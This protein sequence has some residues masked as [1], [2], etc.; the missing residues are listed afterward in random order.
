MKTVM[1]ILLGLISNAALAQ[2]TVCPSV[3]KSGPREA[4]LCW[5]NA[6]KDVNGNKLPAS[7]PYALIETRIQRA[8][9]GKSADCSFD[10]VAQTVTV[11]PNVLARKYTDLTDGKHCFRNRHI[12]KDSKGNELYGTWSKTVSK[13]IPAP[14]TATAEVKKAEPQEA[15]MLQVY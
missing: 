13:V 15:G 6:G 14:K 7:G 10:T 1:L 2:Q 11:K 4:Q 3:P 8:K 5:V 9:V 12:S